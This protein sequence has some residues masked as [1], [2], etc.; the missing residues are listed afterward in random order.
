MPSTWLEL[1]NKLLR[2]VNDVEITQADFNST[3]GVQAVAKDYIQD[4]CRQI[5][6]KRPNWPF[7]AVEHHQ[8]LVAGSEEYAWPID[9]TTAEWGSF[10]IQEDDSLGSEYKTL[11]AITRDEWYKYLRDKDYTSGDDGLDI[12]VYC[13][14]SHG[15]GWGVSPTP[16]AAYPIRY[17]YY[18][19]PVDMTEYDDETTIPEKFD[20]VI[21]AGAL[22]HMNLFKENLDGAAMMK[23][24]FNEGLADMVAAF[25][26]NETSMRSGAMNPG[27]GFRV[28]DKNIWIGR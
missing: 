25:L 2:R 11:K 15:N 13:F 20:Y 26:P 22:Y 14:P 17:R 7:N 23:D 10:Q 1:T 8:D 6:T 4:V 27:G 12:P 24:A 21:M 28:Y 3:R 18:K 5:S 19:T 16:D 9:F